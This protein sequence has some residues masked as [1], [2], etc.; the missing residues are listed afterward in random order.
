MATDNLNLDTLTAAQTDKTTTVNNALERLDD[1]LGDVTT[2]DISASGTVNLTADESERTRVLRMTGTLTS[3]TTVRFA[4]NTRRTPMILWRDG[5]NAGF[6]LTVQNASVSTGHL[7]GEVRMLQDDII[8]VMKTDNTTGQEGTFP[9]GEPMVYVEGLLLGSGAVTPE[10]TDPAD[11]VTFADT[12]PDTITRAAGSFI[13]EGYAAGMSLLWAATASNNFTYRVSAVVAL[14]LTLNAVETV[15]AEGPVAATNSLDNEGEGQGTTTEKP[16]LFLDDQVVFRQLFSRARVGFK[17]GL[18]GS[19]A[20]AEVGATG[21]VA[22]DIRK[23]AAS[24]GA[25]TSVG[26]IDFAATANVATFTFSADADFEPGDIME[27]RAPDTADAS[28]AEVHFELR[29]YRH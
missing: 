2:R 4:S 14:T 26:S 16:L 8:E 29:G 27:I 12:D 20:K 1:L 19:Q 23:I 15:V 24:D 6:T 7:V 13:T 17:S 25:D 3:D 10:P 28:L 5:D 11:S 22:F 18:G 21:A 9:T